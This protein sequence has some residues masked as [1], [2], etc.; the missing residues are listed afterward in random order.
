M[1][2]ITRHISC[3]R[4]ILKLQIF[5]L[6]KNVFFLFWFT[7]FSSSK[8][9]VF[10]SNYWLKPVSFIRSPFYPFFYLFIWSIIFDN[11]LYIC[12]NLT[13]GLVEGSNID[14]STYY[15]SKS[16]YIKVSYTFSRILWITR[17]CYPPLSM[18]TL[19]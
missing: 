11:C 14:L 15:F 3:I 19:F 4:N 16:L 12:S 9:I 17:F 6:T 18:G 10:F 2:N 5:P 8:E 7:V 13:T 1:I